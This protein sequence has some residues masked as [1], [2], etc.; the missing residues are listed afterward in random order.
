MVCSTLIVI[1]FINKSTLCLGYVLI[2]LICVAMRQTT[3]PVQQ[4]PRSH[5]YLHPCTGTERKNKSHLQSE[6][7]DE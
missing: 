3:R 7:F 5:G 4:Q 1:N 6:S 2:T